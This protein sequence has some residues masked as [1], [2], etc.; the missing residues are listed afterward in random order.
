[1]NAKTLARSTKNFV[2]NHRVAIAVIATATVFMISNKRNAEGL[3]KFLTEHGID[4]L[5]YW[6]PDHD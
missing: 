4:P 6:V 2:S 3:D 5:D 1:M